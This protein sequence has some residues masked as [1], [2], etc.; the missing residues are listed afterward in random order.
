MHLKSLQVLVALGVSLVPWE[1]ASAGAKPPEILPLSEVHRGMT[2]YGMTTFAGTKPERFEFEV[3]GVNRNFL[4]KMD[5]ILVKSTDPKLEV[6]GFWQGMSGSPLYV[7]GK[8]MC[9]FS[10]GF[11]YNKLAIG[12]CTPIEYMIEQGFV[13][14]RM[15]DIGGPPP[16]KTARARSRRTPVR[17]GAVASLAEWLE[18]SPDGSV[19]AALHHMSGPRQPWIL[20]TPLPR[21]PRA[22]PARDDHG[23]SAAAVPLALSGF[24]APAFAEAKQL[25][26]SYAVEPMRAGGT[27]DP[28]GGP[29]EFV[30][31]APIGV[32][33]LRGDMSMTATGT[34]S[35]VDDDRLL[36]F[37]H[38]LFR[39]GEIYAPV[40]ASEVHTV[41]PSAQM[42]YVIASPMRELG[43][44]VQDRQSMIMADTGLRA[45]MIPVD[46][47]ITP[48]SGGQAG[49]F[50]V[51]LL[52]NRFYTA[53]LAGISAMNA[54]GRY[55]PDRADVTVTMDSTVYLHGHKP[56]HF[57]D[58]LYA[59]E[60][61]RAVIS[62]SRGLRV[63]VPLL[64]NPFAPIDIDRVELSVKVDFATNYGEIDHLSLPSAEL[65]PGQRNYIDV[66]MT[67]YDDEPFVERVPF[68]VPEAV[69]GAIVKLTV[70]AGDSAGVDAAPPRSLDDLLAAFR[71][72]MPGNVIAVVMA[73]ADEGIAVDGKL[74]RDLP[75]SALDKFKVS[76][77]NPDSSVYHVVSRSSFPSSRVI[78]GSKSI[79]AKV[80]DKKAD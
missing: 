71:K 59:E 11:P 63:L 33:L 1:V 3:I 80:A 46:I 38:P 4:P 62:G 18:I 36:A 50:H 60:G 13:P 26:S 42:A 34:V 48:S 61:A 47:S 10:Y 58:Y 24:S 74:I 35:Y 12:G 51:E 65:K 37:G 70:V 78:D 19:D 8:L 14:R 49:Q 32:Q 77:A 64:N 43:S 52:D 75:A 17:G 39:A 73:T 67:T 44:L 22:R 79:L 57:V 56:L 30:P 7:D 66:H 27:G 55:L 6:S 53:P 2:G 16:K 68:D 69:A 41:L 25:M 72:L 40:A 9:A 45:K 21:A 5:I 76:S 29:T 15:E 54:I 31:G 20:N 23:M 28:E